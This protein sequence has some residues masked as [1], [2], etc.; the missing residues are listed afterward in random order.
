M[1]PIL[2][3][4]NTQIECISTALCLTIGTFCAQLPKRFCSIHVFFF[5]GVDMPPTQFPVCLGFALSLL[6]VVR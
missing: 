3:I 4:C 1:E 2:F 5:F 6:H